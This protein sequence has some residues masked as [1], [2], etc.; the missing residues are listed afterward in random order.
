[1]D[2][3]F[4]PQVPG[5]DLGIFRQPS[6]VVGDEPQHGVGAL[7]QPPVAENVDG[8]Q[9]KHEYQQGGTHSNADKPPLEPFQHEP[10]SRV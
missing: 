4:R 6:V 1:M 9:Q 2:R 7:E 8:R 5:E 10:S 3:R